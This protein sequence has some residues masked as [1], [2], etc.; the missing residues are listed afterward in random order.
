MKLI[1]HIPHEA[2]QITLFWWNQKY[3]LK[4]EKNNLEQTYK[5]SELDFS[6]EEVSQIPENKEFMKKIL[7]RFKQMQRDLQ[8]VLTEN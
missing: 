2:C 6:E 8:E 4:F 5:I 7:D 3:L 1:R